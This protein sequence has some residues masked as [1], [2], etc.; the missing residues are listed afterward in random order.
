MNTMLTYKYRLYTSEPVKKRRR[1]KMYVKHDAFLDSRIDIAAEIW[2]HCIAL[3][4]RYYKLY[5]KN[6]SANRLKVHITKLKKL[7]K[8]QHW[9]DLGSQAIQDVVERIDKSYKAFFTHLREHR[10]GR[11]SP[12][13]FQKKSK[14]LSFTLKQAGYRFHD[15]NHITI[16]G[17][18]YK[19]VAHRPFCGTVKTVTVKRTGIGDYYLCVCVQ[20]ELPDIPTRTGNAVG[21]DFGLKNFLTLDTGEV[22]SAPEFYKASLDE[23]QK[24]H[25]AVS[26]CR[27]GSNNRKRA[28]LHLQKVYERVSNQRR[29]WFFKLANDLVFKYDVLC[30]EDLN[31]DAMK[32]LWGRKVSD[33]GYAEFISILEWKASLNGCRVVR[34]PRFYSS[35]KT[36]HFCGSINDALTLKDRTWECPVCHAHLDR[37]VN[38]AQ[39]IRDLFY[40]PVLASA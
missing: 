13:R 11:K 18:D 32:R 21:M 2:N 15:G 25:R 39:N 38:A 12:P 19:Y 8:Y 37:D 22:I 14:Y 33:L 35:S 40:K 17:R 16:M 30:I 5:G 36:C 27:K 24:A 23:L 9:N 6:L 28:V 1:G 20:E 34:V 10:S 4:R 26:H 31:L 29:D 7:E 3:H